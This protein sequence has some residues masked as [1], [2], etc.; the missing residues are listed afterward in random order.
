MSK[1]IVGS[2][3]LLFL[4]S[5]FPIDCREQYLNRTLESR[6][7][8]KF[9]IVVNAKYGRDSTAAIV[10]LNNDLY[11]FLKTKDSKYA[12][13]LVYREFVKEKISKNDP[14]SFTSK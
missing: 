5:Y 3:I 8:S 10:I 12:D 2:V 1:I 14:F 11:E 13:I 6:N 4:C 9:Y 7:Y